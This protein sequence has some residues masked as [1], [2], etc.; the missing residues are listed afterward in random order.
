MLKIKD[1]IIRIFK[2]IFRKND[3]PLIANVSKHNYDEYHTTYDTLSK[4]FGELDDI[5]AYLVG[6]F[7]SAIQTNQDKL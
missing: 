5:N 2:Q 1:K 3:F 4:I 7:S 6:G